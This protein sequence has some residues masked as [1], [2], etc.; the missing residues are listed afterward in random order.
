MDIRDKELDGMFAGSRIEDG[1]GDLVIP[2]EANTFEGFQRWAQSEVFPLRGHICYLD[3]T[4][5][6]DLAPRD[7]YT[8]GVVKTEIFGQLYPLVEKTSWGNVF[9]DT[10][11]GCSFARFSVEPDITVVLW[12]SLE[13]GRVG[14]VPAPGRE[15]GHY[16]GLEGAPDLV[17]E[18]VSDSSACRDFKFLPAFYERAGIPELW[19]VDAR[20][21]SLL[22]EIRG[23]GP[24]GYQVLPADGEGWISSPVLGYR[25]RLRRSRGQMGRWRYELEH[26]PEM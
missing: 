21:E 17:V 13:S 23:L 20:R 6:V 10:R 2:A 9:V 7:L 5:E 3:G 19:M 25:F 18:V 11:I 16:I 1:E 12:E 15:N 14:E 22:F 8:H 24:D 4:V 26:A